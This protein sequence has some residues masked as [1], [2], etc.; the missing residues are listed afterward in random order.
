MPVK[1]R[2]AM[3]PMVPPKLR[4][5]PSRQR[6]DA[7]PLTLGTGPT[8]YG[9]NTHLLSAHATAE[10]ELMSLSLSGTYG[11]LL[12][13]IGWKG[14]KYFEKKKYFLTYTDVSGMA[15]DTPADSENLNA[16]APGPESEFGS[17]SYT[18][19][20]WQNIKMGGKVVKISQ[21]DMTFA[22]SSET[23][24]VD[25][26]PINNEDEWQTWLATSSLLKRLNRSIITNTSFGL[27]T[28]VNTTYASAAVDST[29]INWN[30]ND[31]AGLTPA[32]AG[33]TYNGAAVADG[34]Q[35]IDLLQYFW[36]RMLMRIANAPALSGNIAAQDV[37]LVVPYFM[38]D[39]LLNSYVCHQI[40][41]GDTSLLNST[42][43]RAERQR[44]GDG[45]QFGF[46]FI[47]LGNTMISLL[48]H[49]PEMIT[50][51][52]GVF[53]MFMLVRGVG[54]TRLLEGQYL[55]QRG[56]SVPGYTA[57]DD[58]K[59][60]TW[61]NIDNNCR[62]RQVQLEWRVDMPGPWAQL[63]ITNVTAEALGG[64]YSADTASGFFFGGTLVAAS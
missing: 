14:V 56:V 8:M 34:I 15:A 39:P 23:L 19:T 53:D 33:V 61:E 31:V 46:G 21:T 42:E 63:R 50:D 17:T 16:C 25:G 24:R 45:G 62:Q 44:V 6:R 41:G 30:G 35:L 60:M 43:A 13:W 51:T 55:D 29:V 28:L 58:G 36:Y 52:T 57:L 9:E 18:L 54:N 64:V 59:L 12:D 26:S 20:G 2:P 7:D 3:R 37:A 47:E 32:S 49:D 27:Q 10:N 1:Q 38:I 4:N 11:P 5:I 22:E 48:P 40:C